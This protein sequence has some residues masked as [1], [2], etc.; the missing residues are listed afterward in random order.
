MFEL[1]DQRANQRGHMLAPQPAAS[2]VLVV[3]TVARTIAD[4]LPREGHDLR[5]KILPDL[6]HALARQAR[7]RTWRTTC[8]VQLPP[9]PLIPHQNL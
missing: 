6:L 4:V 5:A 8:S 3:A 1:A 7:M 9:G 2:V